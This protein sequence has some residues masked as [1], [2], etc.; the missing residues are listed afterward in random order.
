MKTGVYRAYDYEQPC[1]IEIKHFGS[2]EFPTRYELNKPSLTY[3]ARQAEM[4]FCTGIA[5]T[6]HLYDASL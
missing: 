3:V 4:M 6:R 2:Y 1:N 5:V